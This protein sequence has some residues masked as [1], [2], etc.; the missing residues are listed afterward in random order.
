MALIY[1]V[2]GTP[3]PID[4]PAYTRF[5]AVWDSGDLSTEAAQLAF[6]DRLAERARLLRKAIL[7]RTVVSSAD[8]AFTGAA[9]PGSFNAGTYADPLVAH[10][11]AIVRDAAL[12][13]FKAA[14]N[15][16]S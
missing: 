14:N 16:M 5:L 12:D 2:V 7:N 15:D 8:S 4:D 6:A 13:C 10:N 1:T 3:H 11:A 9:I